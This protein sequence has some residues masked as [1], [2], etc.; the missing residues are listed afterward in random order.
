MNHLNRIYSC[1]SESGARKCADKIAAELTRY[2][3]TVYGPMMLRE[4]LPA[5]ITVT[6]DIENTGV[7][8]C[9][10]SRYADHLVR[11]WIRNNRKTII[12]SAYSIALR[13]VKSELH[14]STHAAKNILLERSKS[15]FFEYQGEF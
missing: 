3:Q 6:D 1:Q 13:K 11:A 14:I 8:R 10:R 5:R 4:T 15:E 9:F 7:G 2:N 12:E